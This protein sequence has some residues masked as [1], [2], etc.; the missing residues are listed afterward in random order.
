LSAMLRRLSST[1]AATRRGS[2][3]LFTAAT[4]SPCL[5]RNSSAA[6]AGTVEEV[7]AEVVHVPLGPGDV[8]WFMFSG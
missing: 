7:E 3:Y 4:T 6:S 8:H 1:F 2:R 5:S